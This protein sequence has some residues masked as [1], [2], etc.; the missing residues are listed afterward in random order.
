MNKLIKDII[1]I[2]FIVI[3]GYSLLQY[4]SENPHN[5]KPGNESSWSRLHKKIESPSQLQSRIKKVEEAIEQ[6]DIKINEPWLYFSNKDDTFFTVYLAPQQNNDNSYKNVFLLYYSGRISKGRIKT[7][8]LK[9]LKNVAPTNYKMRIN[10]ALYIYHDKNSQKRKFYGEW[11]PEYRKLRIMLAE[12]IVRSRVCQTVALVEL[13]NFHEVY[14]SARCGNYNSIEQ[15]IKEIKNNAPI[16]S[17]IVTRY[18]K[19]KKL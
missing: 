19:P 12:K 10:P 9:S 18:I 6:H 11:Y 13:Y 17:R 1:F 8:Q 2:S 15:T 7:K 3:L 16:D 5:I 14:F 4:M